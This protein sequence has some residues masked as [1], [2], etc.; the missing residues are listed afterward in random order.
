MPDRYS[1]EAAVLERLDT[2]Y[3]YRPDGTGEKLETGV[4]SIQT[5]AGAR[6]YAVLAFPFDSS[7][8]RMEVVYARVRRAEG[9][10][11]ASAPADAQDL[12]TPLTRAAPQFSDTHL[13]LLPVKGMA[14]H[15]RLEYQVRTVFTSAR[16][17][18]QFWGAENLSTGR[19][20]LERTVELHVPESTRVTVA[21]PHL[22]PQR[23]SGDGETVF[24]WTALEVRPAQDAPSA[25]PNGS[26]AVAWTTFPGWAQVGTW[27]RD[28]LGKAADP[29]AEI[30][31]KADQ[32][33]YRA[34]GPRARAQA[35]F[36]F[37]AAEIRT[38]EVPWG[39]GSPQPH[40]AAEVLASQ[41]G[42][43]KDKAVLLAAMLRAEGLDA[44]LAFTSRYRGSQT[45]MPAP[46]FSAA[47]VCMPEAAGNRTWLN[48]LSE[49]SS[50][51]LLTADLRGRDALVIPRTGPATLVS[52]PADLP[53][54][55]E[56]HFASSGRLT[57]DGTLSAHVDLQMQGDPA[58]VYR[59]AF[60]AAV[61]AGWDRIAGS[62]LHG[63]GMAGE[64]SG[65]TVGHLLDTAQPLHISFDLS[66]SAYSGGAKHQLLPLEPGLE[67]PY[68]QS[69]EAPEGEIDL[70]GIHTE[71]ADS[72]LIL[73][74]ALTVRSGEPVHLHT[75]FADLDK[76]YS[77]TS[78]A[79]G[80]V[81]TVQRTLTIRQARLPAGN[82]SLYRRFLDQVEESEPFL[83]LISS[84]GKDELT[85]PTPKAESPGAARRVQEAQAALEAGDTSTAAKK[86]DEA[87]AL[88]AHQT[89]L[90]STYAELAARGGRPAEVLADLRRELEFHPENAPVSRRLAAELVRQG[91]TREAIALL[92]TAHAR[93]PRDPLTTVQLAGLLLPGAP[94]EAEALLR[95]CMTENPGDLR[96]QLTLARVL[97]RESKQGDAE[98]LLTSVA[99]GSNDPGLLNDAAYL[100]AEN[101]LRLG[102]AEMAARRAVQL[103]NFAS[104][105]RSASP[106][107][108]LLATRNLT[109]TWDTF[110]FVLMRE[111]NLSEAEIW[112]HAAWADSL[113]P[114]AG[115]HYAALLERQGRTAQARAILLKAAEAKRLAAAWNG[116]GKDLSGVPDTS[117]AKLGEG[118]TSPLRKP[119]SIRSGQAVFD[120]EYSG[121]AEPGVLLVQGDETFRS[122]VEASTALDTATVLPAG[123]VAHLTRQIIV[124]CTS[125]DC[126][127][128]LLPAEIAGS[129]SLGMPLH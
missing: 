27:Y 80:T 105:Q 122:L 50:F 91:D 85:Q 68:A 43:G 74:E 25:D 67:L 11:I 120:L 86:L 93:N 35:L 54:P 101:S 71:R 19:V 111:N 126:R 97:L 114:T 18:G 64:P 39:E 51:G 7:V 22:E 26:P 14:A 82:W 117:S 112:L 52:T 61:P 57:A 40:T 98:R 108:A 8:S 78:T 16:V 2:S 123:T 116:L 66:D 118:L 70:G 47:L 4:V 53:F 90:W 38:I 59:E 88:D 79:E 129:P 36:H 81:L 119:A 115:S 46:L 6:A 92:R 87:K 37:V 125:Q 21:S 62:Y 5:E 58:L 84:Q 73:P 24:R 55:G 1:R 72:R 127:A 32:V 30:K 76:T 9:A 99:T 95:S 100:L 65:T 29:T 63:R 42:D 77:V 23:S 31:A 104:L 83:P 44:D 48:P 34:A 12:P 96:V 13:F 69:K 60:A 103:L 110:G 106:E 28:L 49:A 3:L 10:P 94:G 17:P 124:R 113:S 45:G 121:G 109:A 15:S 20:V 89:A 107:A 128:T 75:A 41:F 102:T 56:T 33:V